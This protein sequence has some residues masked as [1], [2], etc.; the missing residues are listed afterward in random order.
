MPAFTRIFP[1]PTLNPNNP[2]TIN[3][4][5]FAE[6][7][8]ATS[9]GSD[10]GSAT[11]V[12]KV[13]WTQREFAKIGLLGW[14][15]KWGQNG[16]PYI[17]RVLPHRHKSAQWGWLYARSILSCEGVGP[18]GVK[19]TDGYETYQF[20]KLTTRYES[21]RCD[22]LEDAAVQAPV[23]A[24]YTVSLSSAQTATSSWSLT[25]TLPGGATHTWIFTGPTTAA[26][27][28]AAIQQ[29]PGVQCTVTPAGN[30]GPWTIT[31]PASA[32]AVTMT[33]AGILTVTPTVTL[34]NAGAM[35]PNE[36]NFQ[37]YT[38]R[39]YRVAQQVLTT[40][41]GNWIW[42][43]GPKQGH[44]VTQEIPIRMGRIYMNFTVLSVPRN[45]I[46]WTA[47]S[48]CMNKCNALPFDPTVMNLPRGTV[49]MLEP[50]I[51]DFRPLPDGVLGCDLS[52]NF[53]YAAEG[54]NRFI[55]QGEGATF[56]TI[57]GTGGANGARPFPEVDFSNLLVPPN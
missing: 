34:T 19:D 45:L 51:P 9:V 5:E 18:T 17:R 21:Y 2:V 3:Y 42:V 8:E 7:T 44:P 29:N 22:F 57:G 1:A 4:L 27:I 38:V 33:G 13:P 30:A 20:A 26:T 50:T 46:N 36:S 49:M 55:V 56:A 11:C 12:W 39:R 25:I 23:G 15:F 24:V 37:R 35:A 54:I 10:N 40:R 48:S 52:M 28:Q 32:G 14:Q 41:M 43:D 6:S 16:V 53:L 31:F 47:I